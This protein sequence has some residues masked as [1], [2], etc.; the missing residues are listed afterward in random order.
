MRP[1]EW[2]LEEMSI[3]DFLKVGVWL[4]ILRDNYKEIICLHLE[5]S[6]NLKVFSFFSC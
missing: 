1:Y 4:L 6:L 2:A 3:G 5:N